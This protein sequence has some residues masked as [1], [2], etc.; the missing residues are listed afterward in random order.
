MPGDTLLVWAGPEARMLV[1]PVRGGEF[2]TFVAVVP[3]P[4]RR[5]ESWSAPGDL[6]SLATVFNGWNTEV[7]S[8]VAA[9][10][11]TRRW[12]LYDREPLDSW[13]SGAETL[14]GD[15]AH[16]ML[17]HHG[18]GAGQAIEDAAVLAHCLEALA[19]ARPA[20]SAARRRITA[21]LRRY[22][23]VRRPHTARVQLGSRGGGS[24]RLR[25]Q[26]G[27]ETPSGSM[28]S[29]IQDVSWIQRHDA[30]ADFARSA[31]PAYPSG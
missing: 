23:A 29:L 21:A 24:L 7:K 10:R 26:T 11:E 27:G 1:H 14:L 22:E 8:L 30:E 15:A 2:L 13:G 5:L 31:G 4:G 19:D 17:P 18:Q 12:A 20:T 28:S 9:V 3:D 25:P 16:P 6:D